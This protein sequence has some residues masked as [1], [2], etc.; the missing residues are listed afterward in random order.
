MTTPVA[1]AVNPG[2][3]LGIVGLVLSIISLQPFGLIVSIVGMVK[4]R[5]SGLGNGFALAGIIISVV[6]IIVVGIVIAVAVSAGVNLAAFCTE[7]GAG[8]FDNNGVTVTC[9]A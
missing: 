4:S 6:G 2:K 5:K 3:T 9:G 1:S 8:V 7:H